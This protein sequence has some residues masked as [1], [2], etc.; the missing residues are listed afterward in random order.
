MLEELTYPTPEFKAA[1][2]RYVR[3]RLDADSDVSWAWKARFKVGGYPTLIVAD[4][5]LREIG[6]VVGWLPAPAL[7]RTLEELKRLKDQPVEAS[8]DRLRVGRWHYERGEYAL[9]RKA[10]EG[11][12]DAEAH[13]YDLL[14][15]AELAKQEDRKDDLKSAYRALVADF[16]ADYE[17]SG[18]LGELLE[19]DKP[20]A[21]ARLEQSK[22]VADAWVND[23]KLAVTGETKGDVFEGEAELLDAA[24]SAEDAKTYYRKAA[25]AF[26]AMAE[27]S[28][29]ALSRGPNIERA[30]CLRKAGETAAAGALYEKLVA[31]YPDEFTFRRAYAEMLSEQGDKNKAYEQASLA[32]E[33]SYGDNWLRAVHLKA[34]LELDLGK[35]DQAR[36]TIESALAEASL[37]SSTQL[38]T[39]R[40][41]AKLRGLLAKL[42]QASAR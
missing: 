12:K 11:R 30:Y 7:A 2:A 35:K 5:Q 28:P 20:F 23:P 37:P 8:R 17:L 38:R 6:R 14:S 1:S 27:R 34:S 4:E 36:R 15:E 40:Y 9:A 39:H 25:E 13:R 26:G 33:H 32:V 22:A 16:P 21:S 29:L 31:A 18:W 19:L 24:G 42:D 3:L 10:F 41:I